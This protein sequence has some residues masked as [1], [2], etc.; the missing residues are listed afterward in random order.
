[1]VIYHFDGSRSIWKKNIWKKNW[2]RRRQE[3]V[4][5]DSPADKKSP[6]DFSPGPGFEVR[7]NPQ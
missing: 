7:F 6:G 1:M 2:K 3:D 5:E 4:G